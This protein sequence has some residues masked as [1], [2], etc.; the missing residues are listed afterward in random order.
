[1]GKNSIYFGTFPILSDFTYME[2]F[3]IRSGNL[4]IVKYPITPRSVIDNAM[5]I[6]KKRERKYNKRK[7]ASKKYRIG[8][9]DS[10]ASQSWHRPSKH[11]RHF[12]S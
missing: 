11:V 5:P 3:L 12:L 7:N 4:E 10:A 6:K 9:F 2:I 1:M 8:R